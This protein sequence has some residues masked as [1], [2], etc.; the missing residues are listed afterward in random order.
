MMAR[1]S[2]SYPDTR[3]S[4]GDETTFNVPS[5]CTLKMFAKNFISAVYANKIFFRECL[6]RRDILWI[7]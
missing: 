3:A 6:D 7:F 5:V 4:K 1:S 2:R